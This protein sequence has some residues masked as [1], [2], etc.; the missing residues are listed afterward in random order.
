MATN[1]PGPSKTYSRISSYYKQVKVFMLGNKIQQ[2]SN[3]NQ[4]EDGGLSYQAEFTSLC[5]TLGVQNPQ[6]VEAAIKTIRNLL[7]AQLQS[8]GPSSAPAKLIQQIA[9]IAK[10]DGWAED[11][12]AL[13]LNKST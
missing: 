3:Y 9:D 8:A 11:L 13:G 7:E 10:L 4:F 5:Q 2:R 6:N 12:R 1:H